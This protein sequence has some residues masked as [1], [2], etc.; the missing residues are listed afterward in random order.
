M[1][2]PGLTSRAI[3]SLSRMTRLNRWPRSSVTSISRKRRPAC[4]PSLSTDQR[5]YDGARSSYHSGERQ[6]APRTWRSPATR[7]GRGTSVCRYEKL[8]VNPSGS[9]KQACLGHGSP[10]ALTKKEQPQRQLMWKMSWR[11]CGHRIGWARMPHR[12]AV[13]LAGRCSSTT[14][15]RQPQRQ[16]FSLSGLFV[17][18]Q[19]GH[20]GCLSMLI[21]ATS[22][23][24]RSSSPRHRTWAVSPLVTS[25]RQLS[26]GGRDALDPSP[27]LLSDTS[28]RAGPW[29]RPPAARGHGRGG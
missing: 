29:R 10:S 26:P 3:A 14:G 28:P 13:W 12:A 27:D 17:A 8:H 21:R 15:C 4:S 23:V 19:L 2:S 5:A 6:F 1:L 20:R 25:G 9:V 11:Q 7:V 22:L 18:R 16:Q 24:I